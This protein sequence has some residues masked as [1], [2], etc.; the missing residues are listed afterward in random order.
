MCFLYVNFSLINVYSTP[1]HCLRAGLD[2]DL[3]GWLGQG[4]IFGGMGW[5]DFERSCLWTYLICPVPSSASSWP[6]PSTTFTVSS[7]GIEASSLWVAVLDPEILLVRDIDRSLAYY[8]TTKG[9]SSGQLRG[10]RGQRR[11]S[12]PRR[13]FDKTT[14]SEMPNPLRFDILG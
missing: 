12:N 3:F 6:R 14:V 11:S 9:S 4:S 2:R 13:S 8:E 5:N 1:R 10:F 7:V